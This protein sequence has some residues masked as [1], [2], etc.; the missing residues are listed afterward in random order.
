MYFQWLAYLQALHDT[1][2]SFLDFPFFQ[3]P[4]L[5][6]LILS[7]FHQTLFQLQSLDGV[8]NIYEDNFKADFL[9]FMAYDRV[10]GIIFKTI[11]LTNE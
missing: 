8:A 6:P 10:M 1:D 7:I 2:L 5:T 3:H 4:S 11:S 9:V